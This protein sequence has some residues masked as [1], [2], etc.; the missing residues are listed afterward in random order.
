MNVIEKIAPEYAGAKR[1]LAPTRRKRAEAA[2][3]LEATLKGR[4]AGEVRFDA[5]S[6]AAYAT[7][8]SIYR[9]VPVGVVIPR[10]IEDV[11]ATVDACHAREVPILGRGC[12]SSLS[13]QTCNVAVVIDFSKY[14]NRILALDPDARL[15]RVEPGC[16]ND[17][18]RNAAMQHGL[19]F[20]PDPA[21]H[22]YCTLGGNIGNNSCGAHTVMGGKTVDNVEALEILTYDGLRMTVGATTD[23]QYDLIQ[24]A[25]GRRAEI[26]KGLRDI[27]AR[28]GESIRKHYPRI[29]RRVSGYNLDDLLP[30]NG[31]HVARSLVGSESTCALTLGA[32]LRL[33]PF[34]SHRALMVLG[35]EDPPRAAD[36]VPAI[37]ELHPL[38]IE[39]FGRHLI[40]NEARKG[41]TYSGEKLLPDGG[42]WLLVEFGA[43]TKRE[44]NAKVESAFEVLKHG[45]S[46]ALGM[47]LV[48]SEKEQAELWEM[49][50]DG[51]GASRVPVAEEAWP[52]WEDAAVPPEKLGSYL[53]KFD[54]LNK[55]F[56]YA[57]TLFGHFGD[58]CVHTRMT[59]GLKTAEGVAKFR[60]YMEAAADLVVEHGGSLSG[61]HG[62]GQAKGELLPK[63]YGPD[64]MQAFR[65]F[66]RLWDP[67]WKMNPGK[68]ID[69]RPLD[70]DLRLGPDYHPKDMGKTHF[71]YPNDE[72]SF[73]K[74]T[75]RC[76]GVGKC[77]S[78]GAR[79]MCP[80]FQATREE[81]AST[82]GRARLLFEMVR[83]DSLTNGWNEPAV[84]EALDL[85]LQCKG[86]KHDC[87]VNV[88]MATYKAEFMSHYYKNRLRPRN[89]YAM[90]LIW[91][92]ARLARFAPGIVNEVVNA[93]VL[94]AAARW[95]AGITDKREPPTFAARSFQD[96]FAA[97]P[98][99]RA[100]DATRPAVILW[101]DTWNNYFLPGTAKAAVAV[102]EDAG[103]RVTV[104]TQ[105]LCCGRP[106]YDYGMM[107]LA[108]RKLR[109]AMDVLRP[110][111][112]AG[113]PVVGLEPSCVSVFRDEMLNLFPHDE[114]ARR[115][116]QQTKTL[117]ELLMAT[118]G[119]TPPKLERK[120]LVHMHCHERSVLSPETEQKLLEQMGL[121]LIKNPAGCCG[122]AGAFGY[123]T[124]HY[125]IA[126]NIGEH[127]LL[128]LVRK[129]GRE[130]L[131]ISDGFSC[132]Y[133]MKHGAGRWAMH[134]AEVILMARQMQGRVPKEV[135]EDRY[136]EPG[137]RPGLRDAATLGAAAAGIALSIG[138]SVA[139]GRLARRG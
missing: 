133:Q 62:D 10:N 52:S 75:E 125:D 7:D 17:T 128:P 49:R 67:Q 58:G 108:K 25:G 134:P 97:R 4:I 76:F 98:N 103:Y 114:D 83:G 106:L 112:R 18:L 111:A 110:A 44:A 100:E 92:W 63:M 72:F 47:R 91:Q 80:S 53:R 41:K 85:C 130:T 95:L 70:A 109:E 38:A 55:R 105:R 1:P 26:Y 94:G 23:A 33:I 19:T 60:R 116:A 136:L 29:P 139:A 115:I 48:E 89:A 31:F 132:R 119:W 65:E 32:T 84:A 93:P 101:P 40:D 22:Q 20:A 122:V 13:G 81:F 16:I 36:D 74:A 50:E 24:H 56:G 46:D 71:H 37:R 73:A 45:G 131:M 121:D 113:I 43:D 14:M 124:N 90:G 82:R 15:A 2:R 39:G 54:E 66:K 126:M 118:D 11:I 68:V 30:E 137:A 129:Q 104:P 21:T 69:A 138:L 6:R 77:R 120:A 123:E 35:Y 5:G 34:P 79:I 3:E 8:H 135:P 12:G 57:Y 61:E 59:F 51:V 78:L 9:A 64:L 107:D 88:D 87:P 28:Y 117:S 127:D 99:P 96:W 102:L 42:A 27:A 86:C